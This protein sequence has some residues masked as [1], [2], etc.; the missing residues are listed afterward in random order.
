MLTLNQYIWNQTTKNA[1]NIIDVNS[2]V[3]SDENSV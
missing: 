2:V 1:R 3:I